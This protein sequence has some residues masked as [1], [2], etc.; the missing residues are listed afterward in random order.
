MSI[1]LQTVLWGAGD[2]KGSGDLPCVSSSGK[3][4]SGSWWLLWDT[5][6]LSRQR[7]S[8]W[9]HGEEVPFHF[10]WPVCQS[11]G[12]LTACLFYVL[13]DGAGA[14]RCACTAGCPGGASGLTVSFASLAGHVQPTPQYRFRKRDKV[15][16][17]GR[18]IMRK[19][20]WLQALQDGA[21]QPVV[22]AA[23]TRSPGS[24]TPRVATSW[25]GMAQGLGKGWVGLSWIKASTESEVQ[26][27]L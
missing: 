11:P 24:L 26:L 14:G 10:L 8:P 22:C 15:M 17:Y 5:A 21:Q 27:A 16:F 18:K 20:T 13:C 2:G 4:P 23:F 19:V 6:G 12:T 1:L 3:Q 7:P 9:V 25:A